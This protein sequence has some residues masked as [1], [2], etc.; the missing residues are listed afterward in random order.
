[1]TCRVICFVL[2]GPFDSRSKLNTMRMLAHGEHR[3]L[4]FNEADF[5]AA[6]NE[7]VHKSDLAMGLDL[8]HKA[9]DGR[10]VW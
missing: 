3:L 7:V 6:L 5:D 10:F 9:G 2:S 4:T 8:E 1:M